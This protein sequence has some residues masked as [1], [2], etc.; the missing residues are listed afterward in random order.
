MSNK[1]NC[2][3]ITE[4]FNYFGSNSNL[5]RS[6]NERIILKTIQKH[7]KLNRKYISNY[8]KLSTPTVSTIT[9]QLLSNDILQVVGK[10]HD[11]GRGQPLINLALN[12]NFSSSVGIEISPTSADIYS[13]DFSGREKKSFKAPIGLM[14]A[15]CSSTILDHVSELLKD[16]E[17][18][19]P[20]LGYIGI[21]VNISK[22]DGQLPTQVA[23]ILSSIQNKFNI[24]LL[25]ATHAQCAAIA[26]EINQT[27]N[28]A[29]YKNALYIWLGEELDSSIILNGEVYFGENGLAGS[30][31]FDNIDDRISNNFALNSEY[32]KVQSIDRINLT[33]LKEDLAQ[34]VGLSDASD[35]NSSILTENLEFIDAWIKDAAHIL[36]PHIAKLAH[37]LNFTQIIVGTALPET[38]TASLV[39]ELFKLQESDEYQMNPLTFSRSLAGENAPLV[40]AAYLPIFQKYAPR[41]GQLLNG[42]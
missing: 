38:L 20:E 22:H 39:R 15:D 24:S 16:K 19:S 41:S 35:F 7:K 4:E 33:C 8:T 27:G 29:P 18:Y 31:L 17:Y 10:S 3:R 2:T 34:E 40:G 30:F 21:A 36:Y 11:G 26:E 25:S 28:T 14:E 12:P 42:S 5:A 13:I 6:Y 23:G 9:A 37:T 32:K 1:F